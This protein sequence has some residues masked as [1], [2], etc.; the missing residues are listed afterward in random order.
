[1][2]PVAISSRFLKIVTAFVLLGVLSACGASGSTND[3]GPDS[4]S[5]RGNSSEEGAHEFVVESIAYKEGDEI[6]VRFTCEGE[7]LSPPIAW[8]GV[9]E[10]TTSFA[11][12]MEDPD[13]PIG[14]WVHWVVYNLPAETNDLPA[15]VGS[16]SGLPDGAFHGKNSWGDAVYGG[17]CPP[18]GT[19]RYFIYVF[20]LDTV[21][22]LPA[23][24]SSDILRDTMKGHILGQAQLMGKFSR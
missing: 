15:G 17:P 13:A 2:K 23:G 12:V 14:T 16:G 19:H 7:D 9:P 11:L 18:G 24:A 20:A 3:S 21:L 8:S 4:S 6:P 1:M 10:D 5:A 22:D